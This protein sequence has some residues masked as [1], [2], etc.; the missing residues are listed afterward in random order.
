MRRISSGPFLVVLLYL[1]L[2]GCGRE[3]IEEGGV[4]SKV[5]EPCFP[6]EEAIDRFSG[7]AVSEMAVDFLSADYNVSVGPFCLVYHFQ[8]RA[9]CPYGQTNSDI[10]TLE[11]ADPARCRLPLDDGSMTTEPVV[12]AVLPQL[13]ERQAEKTIY[14]TCACSGND[15]LREYCTCPKSMH[16][17]PQIASEQFS[18]TGFCVRDDSVYNAG[19]LSPTVCSKTGSD[20]STDCGNHRQNP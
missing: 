10:E 11:P 3:P 19:S 4:F 20:S 14:Y 5:G 6:R 2:I 15:K 12:A 16:C 9:S 8:G 7:Y 17:E 1:P 13:T 18:I